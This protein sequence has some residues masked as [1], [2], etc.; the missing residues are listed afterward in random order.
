MNLPPPLI[1]SSETFGAALRWGFDAAAAQGARVI[2]CA[3]PDFEGWPLDDPALLQGLSDWIRL[4]QRQ[5]VLLAA[6]YDGVPQRLPRFAAWRRNWSHAVQALQALP[7]FALDLPT[8]L[9][10]D[11]SVSVQLVDRLQWRGLA[12]ADGRK[13]W[14]LQEKLDVVLQRSE[15]G[16]P[17]STLGL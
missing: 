9:I 4:P 14:L 15:P 13:R 10:D 2:T 16:F 6:S 3:D 17:I 1:E 12:A 7:E 5:L 11:V 8:L